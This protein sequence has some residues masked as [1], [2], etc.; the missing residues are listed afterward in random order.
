MH[1]I[2]LLEND[3]S[4]RRGICF[5]LEKEGFHVLSAGSIRQGKAYLKTNEIQLI[6]CDIMLDDGSGL[7]FC[8][9]VREELFCDIHFIFL[10]AMDAEIDIVMGYETGADD[11]ITKPFSLAV[12]MSKINSIFKR[13]PSG[14][15]TMTSSHKASE[16][17]INKP[18]KQS[19]SPVITS[20]CLL[21][22]PNEMQLFVNQ[23]AVELTR[24]EYK[25]LQLFLNHPKQIL[26]KAQILEQMFDIDGNYVDDNTVAVN[27]RRLREKIKD[28]GAK[29]MIKNIRGIG[30]V[31]DLEVE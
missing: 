20:G 5:K 8:Q 22:Y 19:E 2:L 6:L 7:A 1:T 4:L 24:N 3:E 23:E 21:Y 16:E 18:A 29:R 15:P 11:Y 26:S 17:G 9:Y 12:L 27:I 31:W 10:T 25:L 28:T 13:I 30:Y 14:H